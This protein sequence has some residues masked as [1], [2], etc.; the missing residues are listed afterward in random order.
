MYLVYGRTVRCTCPTTRCHLILTS[1]SWFRGY[2]YFFVFKSVFSYTVWNSS[3]IFGVWNDCKVYMSNWKLSSDLDLFFH[4]LVVK[5]KFLIFF[6]FLKLYAIAI[7][8][9]YLVY[10]NILWC[11]CQSSRFCMTMTSISG[12]VALCLS[13]EF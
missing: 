7:G 6:N 12:F 11:T 2:S 9:L 1:F 10:G 13:F 4:G 5:N 8:Q 3:T